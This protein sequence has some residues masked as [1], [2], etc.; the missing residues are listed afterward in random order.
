MNRM[1]DVIAERVCAEMEGETVVFL[2]GMRINKLWKVWK[3]FP[4]LAAM[5]RMLREL[6]AQPEL[7]LLHARAQFGLR[8]LWVV[9]YWQS[10]EHLR[11]YAKAAGQAHLPAWQAFNASIGTGGDVGI[12]HET[13]VVP[14]GHAE[15]V[16]VNMPRFGLGRAGQLFPATGRRASAAKRLSALRSPPQKQPPSSV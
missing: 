4:V 14:P 8:N 6:A 15:S 1:T 13:Y 7:G 3:W 16:Y 10:A 5:P 9:Q 12:W 2:I 11:A